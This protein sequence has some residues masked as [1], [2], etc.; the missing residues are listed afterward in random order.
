MR[1]TPRWLAIV[2][3]MNVVVGA[4]D[5]WR[6]IPVLLLAAG[7][8][9]ASAGKL[10]P[11]VLLGV[12]Q[13][14][15]GL[16]LLEGF[17]VAHRYLLFASAAR[18]IL[19]WP[20][21]V[22]MATAPTA[23]PLLGLATV[24]VAAIT[25]AY[26]LKADVREKLPEPP[27][28]Q[29]LA[30]D[31]VVA[32]LLI[33]MRQAQNPAAPPV[34]APQAR[35]EQARPASQLPAGPSQPIPA[36]T[37]SATLVPTYD[38]KPIGEF[39]DADV[40]LTLSTIEETP[41]IRDGVVRSTGVVTTGTIE[42]KW[43]VRHGRIRI[44]SVPAGLYR[45]GINI[46]RR[47]GDGP[48]GEDDRLSGGARVEMRTGHG[49]FHE[50][51]PVM[52]AMT[53]REP[54][55]APDPH[56]PGGSLPFG[57][58]ASD[59][60]F[61]RLP[62]VPSRVGLA[63]DPVP[64]AVTYSVALW[65]DDFPTPV[66]ATVTSPSWTTDLPPCT[67][68]HPWS[69]IVSAFGSNG[70][71]VGGT[72]GRAF[73][74]AGTP[75]SRAARGLPPA[76]L[77]LRPTF[78]GRPLPSF[79]DGDV[80]VQLLPATWKEAPTYPP[81]RVRHGRIKIPRFVPGHYL[82]GVMIG[83]GARDRAGCRSQGGDYVGIDAKQVQ[84]VRTDWQP[85]G[86]TFEVQRTIRLVEPEDPPTCEAAVVPVQSPVELRWKPVPEAVDYTLQLTRPNHGTAE[87]QK[88]VLREPVWRGDVDATG[89]DDRYFVNIAARTANGADVAVVHL[90]LAVR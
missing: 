40:H 41:W 11:F 75:E 64:R 9:G 39:T 12:L 21:L 65:C 27:L 57:N 55:T 45:V 69:V 83:P 26:L 84:Y 25:L 67:P 29:R 73:V 54:G 32:L 81:V 30:V 7:H 86:R 61:D 52:Q 77:T 82:T 38:G 31:A 18:V 47:R 37:G 22:H 80:V 19:A 33:G 4:V 60:A 78:D 88:I 3:W 74:V 46:D 44:S 85:D 90:A 17:G 6:F 50:V 70:A 13:V 2:A 16:G 89:P 49:P 51:V 35:N 62:R 71:F 68:P 24:G 79:D 43:R 58:T 59:E 56:V 10:L 20:W 8:D 53:L 76:A 87:A 48:G 34:V 14:V 28:A 42:R 5:G 1:A 15:A 72:S 63:W 66:R 36:G 23:P